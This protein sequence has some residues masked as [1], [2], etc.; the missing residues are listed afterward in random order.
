MEIITAEEVSK[1]MNKSR[2]WVYKHADELGAARIGKNLIFSQEA[3]ADALQG[4]R[5]MA[6][7]CCP[8]GQ[9]THSPDVNQKRSRKVGGG[10]AEGVCSGT[11]AIIRDRLI[12]SLR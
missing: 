5:Q 2:R 4:K 10:K 11:E 7:V 1:R 12:E 9:A 6:G 3:L 8:T